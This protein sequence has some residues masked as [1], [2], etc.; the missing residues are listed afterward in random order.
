MDGFAHLCARTLNFWDALLR[1]YSLCLLNMSLLYSLEE[2]LRNPTHATIPSKHRRGQVSA[3]RWQQWTHAGTTRSMSPPRMSAY[4]HGMMVMMGQV[5]SDAPTQNPQ[6]QQQPVGP[7]PFSN[8]SSPTGKHQESRQA[9]LQLGPMLFDEDPI[10]LSSS[11]S[12]TFSS[13]SVREEGLLQHNH[14]RGSRLNNKS[15]HTTG[16]NTRAPGTASAASPSFS[17][18][19]SLSSPSS[20]VR[21]PMSSPSMLMVSGG[22]GGGGGSGGSRASTAPSYV[23]N[24]GE[25]EEER[26]YK[27]QPP[28]EEETD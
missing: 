21:T 20:P 15:P 8:A 11:G 9:Q 23:V 6:Q 1:S 26:S 19:P 7:Q 28:R 14:H 13:S 5:S 18:P 12:P 16:R 3:P 10:I 4:D 2:Q 22:G 24:Y 17:K 25:R 27:H